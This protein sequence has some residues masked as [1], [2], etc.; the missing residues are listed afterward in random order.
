MQPDPTNPK[1][2]AGQKKNPLRLLPPVGLAYVAMAMKSGAKKY[3]PANWRDL[4][5]SHSVYLEAALRHIELALDGEMAD[6][7]TG[8]PHEAHAAACMLILLDAMECDCLI[9]DRKKTGKLLA[10]FKR[11]A[12]SEPKSANVLPLPP[13]LKTSHAVAA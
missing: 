2:L 4:K 12:A 5:I 1:D 8:L 6:E 13:A 11:L 10:L 7:E 3:G 9:D